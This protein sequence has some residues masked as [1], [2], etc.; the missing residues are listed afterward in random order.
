M[1]DF[2]STQMSRLRESK[3]VRYGG[4]ALLTSLGMVAVL[5][6]V[7]LLVD[8]FGVEADL[9]QNRLFTLSDQ[10]FQLLDNLDAD[11]TVYQI[12]TTG[13]ENPLIDSVLERYARRSSH[14]KLANL[15]PERNPGLAAKYEEEGQ[16]RPAG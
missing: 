3:Q 6:L 7:N 13:R 10:T 2:L 5:V 14:V 15:D 16:V 1:S 8:Q 12:G 11:V 9:T 4:Y